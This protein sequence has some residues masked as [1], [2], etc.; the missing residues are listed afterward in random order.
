MVTCLNF[1]LTEK[2]KAAS[3][4]GATLGEI[5]VYPIIEEEL[6]KMEDGGILIIDLAWKERV[7]DYRFFFTSI[8]PLL[9]KLPDYGN[10]YIIIKIGSVGQRMNVLQGITYYAKGEI[11]NNERVLLKLIEESGYSAIFLPSANKEKNLEYIGISDEK[12]KTIIDVITKKGGITSSELS[13][14]MGITIEESLSLLQ[15]LHQKRL[16][17]FHEC[18]DL[19]EEESIYQSLNY[20]LRKD[21]KEV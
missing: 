20:I 1:R 21:F 18:S 10:K 8:A 2:V 13:K 14:E 6:K 16:I 19:K 12:L 15:G 4:V 7:L 3:F 17:Y 5:N 11:S 9:K